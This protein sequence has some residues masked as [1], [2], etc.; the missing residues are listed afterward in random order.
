M[1]IHLMLPT[2]DDGLFEII[3]LFIKVDNIQEKW[4]LTLC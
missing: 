2:R 1:F 3:E 4:A